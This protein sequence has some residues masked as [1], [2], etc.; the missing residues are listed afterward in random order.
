MH[1]GT[2]EKIRNGTITFGDA[3]SV[4]GLTPA[5]VFSILHDTEAEYFAALYPDD[6]PDTFTDGPHFIPEDFAS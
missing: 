3:V 1:N 5:H 4:Y 2:S 6:D